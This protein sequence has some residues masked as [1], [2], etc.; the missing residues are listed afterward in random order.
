M[1]ISGCILAAALCVSV[2][3]QQS[4]LSPSRFRSVYILEMSNS[5][6]QHLASRISSSH[7]LSVVLDPA[8]ADAV[9][10]DTLD[11]AFWTWMQRTYPPGISEPAEARGGGPT[12]D[13]PPAGGQRGTVFLVDPR[14]RVVLWSAYDLPKNSSPAGLDRTASRI[15]N[16]L[17]VAFGTK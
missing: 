17:K 4:R 2:L 5:L 14:R 6:D 13:N 8:S 11:A 10:T 1:K 7:V 9:L 16:Q 3:G 12:H 15:T